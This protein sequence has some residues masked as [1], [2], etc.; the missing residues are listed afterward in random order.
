M[1]QINLTNITKTF[2]KNERLFNKFSLCVKSNER[3]CLFGPSG[4]GKTTL[5][6]LISGLVKPNSGGVSFSSD[7]DN[8]L[9]PKIG[10]VF[11]DPRLIPWWTIEKNISIVLKNTDHKETRILVKHILKLVLLPN[12]GKKY[13]HQ[14]SGG[15]QQRVSIA[16]ALII[17]P[18]VLLLDEPFSHLDEITATLLRY[19]LL[20]VLERVKTTT[21]FTTHNPLEATY[22]ANRII[23]LS[24]NKSISTIRRILKIKTNSWKKLDLYREF[25]FNN[26]MKK[27]VR[28]L[29]LK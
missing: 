21:I 20:K 25:I 27:T 4:C 5:L 23:V 10:Y 15:E 14:I 11:Q 16:R 6:N 22:L 17:N 3:V 2:N 1:T 19:D 29:F 12:Y 24:K 8:F 26:S 9:T 18:D 28:K 7:T 13:P